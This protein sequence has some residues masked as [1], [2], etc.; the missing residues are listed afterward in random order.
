MTSLIQKEDSNYEKRKNA[1]YIA[2]QI[3]T[4]Q[5]R[6]DEDVLAFSEKVFQFITKD[7][8]MRGDNEQHVGQ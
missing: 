6:Q 7:D 2:K 3:L 4:M 1:I 8:E 5:N